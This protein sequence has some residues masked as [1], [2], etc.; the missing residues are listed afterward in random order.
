ML[1]FA[2]YLGHVPN[3]ALIA[4]RTVGRSAGPGP[5]FGPSDQIGLDGIPLDV[6]RGAHKVLFAHHKRCEPTLTQVASP[7][8]AEVDHSRISTVNLSHGLGQSLNRRG[9]QDQMHVVW[10]QAIRPDADIKLTA[11]MGQQ[12]KI[13]LVVLFAEKRIHATIPALSDMMSPPGNYD[14]RYSCHKSSLAPKQNARKQMI[15]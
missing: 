3:L 6:T 1:R 12:C 14:S 13:L 9:N 7:A 15:Q 10:H 5:I 2:S 11:P 8:L 4:R